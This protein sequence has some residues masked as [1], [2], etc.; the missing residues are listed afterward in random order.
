[1]TIPN[2]PPIYFFLPQWQEQMPAIPDNLDDYW[3][4]QV[5]NFK[6]LSPGTNHWVMQSYLHLKKNNFP[7]TFTYQIPTEGI[8]LTHRICLGYPWKSKRRVGSHFLYLAQPK[9]GLTIVSLQVDY[10]RYPFADFHVVHNKMQEQLSPRNFYI[11]PWPQ[12]NIIPRQSVRGER[13]ENVAFLGELWNL[14]AEFRSPTWQAKLA[15]MGLHWQVVDRNKWH[16]FSQI[17]AI[18]AVRKYSS[19]GYLNKPAL[20]LFNAW[21][22]GVPAIL[23][24]ESAYRME[25]ISELDYFEVT[26]M[27]ETLQVLQRLQQDKELYRRVVDNGLTRAKEMVPEKLV[28]RWEYFLKEIV[29]PA[30]I[31]QTSKSKVL[32]Y[33]KVGGMG[34]SYLKHVARMSGKRVGNVIKDIST[35]V[36]LNTSTIKPRS[37]D[38]T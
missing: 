15:A 29:I 30:H 14:A 36:G 32:F 38:K 4:W 7:C 34:V 35:Q 22:A 6:R 10:G 37:S 26:T 21:H 9:P 1:M 23:G 19:E 31:R 3:K 18:L 27:E 5:A 33:Q 12:V 11:P 2:Y 8:V 24:A 25:R 17:D 28:K 13:L 16:D 20:K